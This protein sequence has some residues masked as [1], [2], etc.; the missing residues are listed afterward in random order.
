[1]TNALTAAPVPQ[2]SLADPSY[3]LQDRYLRPHGRVY[4]TGTQAL[5]RLPLM[6]AARDRA[7]GLTT[8]GYI[9]GYRGSPLGGYDQALWQVKDLLAENAVTFQPA[10]NEDL[11]ATAVLGSQQVEHGGEGTVEGVFA[12]WYGKGPGVDRAGDALKHGHAFGSSPHGGVLVV[13]GDD[14]GV[15]SS[16]MPHQSDHAFIAW[17]MPVLNPANIQEYLDFGLY[18]W[19]LSRFTGAW[20]G[21]KAISETVESAA[22]VEVDPHRLTLTAPSGYTVPVGGLHYRWPDLPSLTIEER[23]AAKLEAVH[24]FVR[25]NPGIDRLLVDAPQARFGIVTTGK[26]SLDLMEALARL[27]LD[28]AGLAALGVRV[29]K[30]GLTWPLEPQAMRRFTA[31]LDEVLVVEEKKGII[32]DQIKTLLYG[33]PGAPK[34]SGKTAPDGRALLASLGEL[35]PSRIAPALVERLSAAFPWLAP[36]LAERLPQVAPALRRFDLPADVKR[37]PYFCSGC[38]HNS[39]TKV[40][41]GSKAYAGIGCHF[42]A[43]WMDRSTEGLVQMGGEGV[44][45]MAQSLFSRRRHVFQ[46]LG[47]GT[48]YHSGLMAIR[49]AIAGKTNITYKILFNDAVAMTGGQPHDGPLTVQE[50]SRQVHAEG[51]RRIAVVSDEPEKYTDRSGF[52]PGCTFHHRSELDPVQRGLAATPGVTVLIYDQACAAEKRRKRKRGKFPDPAR[53]LFINEAVCEGCG[54]CTAKSN[55]LSVQPVETEFGR[56]RQIDQSS[57]NKDFSCVEGFCPS[58]VSV[59]GGAVRKPQSAGDFPGFRERVAALPLPAVPSVSAEPW[60]IL[61][62]GIGGTGVVTVGALLCMAAHLEGKGA[63]VLDFMG[64]AQKGG[65]VLSHVRIGASP[66]ALRQVRIDIGQA[67]V[68]LACDMVVATTPEALGVLRQGHSRVIC[69]TAEVP[70]GAFMRN[71]DATLQPQRLTVA[72]EQAVG[73][74]N[75]DLVDASRLATAL[76]GDSIGSNLFLLGYAWQK[77]LLP[78]SLEAL[79]KAIDL[80]GVA[81]D[82]NKRALAW[83]RMAAVDPAYVTDVAAGFGTVRPKLAQDVDSVIAARADDLAGYQDAAYAERFRRI[84]AQVRQAEAAV[85]SGHALTLAAARGLYRL[86]AYKD[87]Y[88]V[89]RRYADPAFRARLDQVFDGDYK[90]SLHLAP[91][92]LPLG[93]TPGGEPRKHEFGRWIFPVLGVVARLKGLRGTRFDPFGWTAERR[94]ERALIAEYEALLRDLCAGLTDAARLATAVEIAAAADDIRGFGAVK[95]K[96]AQ[97]VRQ[98]WADLLAVFRSP[99]PQTGQGRE[100]RLLAAE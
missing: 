92:L 46:N 81:R 48:Y 64:F 82:A 7:A 38:P 44:N 37:T 47:D 87:E 9:S 20:V 49:Q 40:P 32:E 8:A 58:F 83:G 39:S 62:T 76:L 30:L 90:V 80:N 57:C 25:A 95:E 68:L 65:A 69:N 52:A 31:G 71:R 67:E 86:M 88:E 85:S 14:H 22:S 54:D 43:N 21:F 4:L 11:A 66:Q 19:A 84:I 36:D 91:P 74:D 73:G 15:V 45:W 100:A 97:S 33:Q 10:I 12:I 6:Q 27:G 17:S 96:A 77:G 34:V 13:A 61:V 60:E 70:T 75:L 72:L 1:M 78:V 42:M 93:R 51:V 29:L 53:R 28:E 55:C 50:I 56:K 59:R 99:A 94:M 79:E 18:G 89:A 35:R 3:T 24:A 98:R 16:S 26:A 5:V 63:S 23:M 41:E 2:T